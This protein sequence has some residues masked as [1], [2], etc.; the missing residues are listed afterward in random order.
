MALVKYL[1]IIFFLSAYFIL[2]VWQ[3]TEVMK[4]KMDLEKKAGVL[5]SLVYENDR[6]RY[7]IAQYKSNE[8]VEEYAKKNG[9][10]RIRQD[11]YDILYV[12]KED[13]D[14]QKDNQ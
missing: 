4:L 7:R 12:M 14:E 6:L 3:N 8:R 13:D 5:K 11:D 1:A 10:R 2:Y 9:Y